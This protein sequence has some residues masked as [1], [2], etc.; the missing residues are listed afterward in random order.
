MASASST[1][2][3]S[4][5][6][7]D[8]AIADVEEQL[9]MVFGRARLVWKDAA[10]QIH[11]ELKPVGYKILSTIVRL[12]ETNAFVLAEQLETDKSVV[13][14]QV[15]MLEYAGLVISRS[16]DKDRR[17]RVLSASPAAVERVRTVRSAQQNR[18]RDLL[19]S[20]PEHEVRAFAQM[21]H[22]LNEN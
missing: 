6:E 5:G 7:L 3:A 2:P 1:A 21:L 22:L 12:G 16:D 9:G 10:A 19:R 17:S 4:R 13:S 11:P 18:L 8:E 14:R 15:R 20:R